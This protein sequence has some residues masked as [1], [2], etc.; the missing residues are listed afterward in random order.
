MVTST[1]QAALSTLDLVDF[2]CGSPDVQARYEDLFKQVRL[3]RWR[4]KGRNRFRGRPVQHEFS[5]TLEQN[6][7]LIS[8]NCYNKEHSKPNVIT[9]KLKRHPALRVGHRPAPHERH[10]RPMEPQFPILPKS[11]SMTIMKRLINK[12]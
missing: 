11:F 4:F 10:N 2:N 6:A 7:S 5:A 12:I 1:K 3:Q 9:R 8:F